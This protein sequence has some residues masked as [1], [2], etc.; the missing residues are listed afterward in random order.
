[1]LSLLRL[2]YFWL[3]MHSIFILGASG[4]SFD[5]STTISL[6]V[7]PTQASV[8]SQA[9][10]TTSK[11]KSLRAVAMDSLPGPATSDPYTMVQTTIS[12]P[13]TDTSATDSLAS[14]TASTTSMSSTSFS[15]QGVSGMEFGVILM[16]AMYTPIL[17]I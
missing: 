5:V 13:T 4:F 10:A 15:A 8:G 11:T 9:Q 14:E 2:R 3:V 1:M 12:T 17:M 16:L 6:F 7:D